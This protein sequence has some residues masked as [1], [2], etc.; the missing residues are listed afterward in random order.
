MA[1]LGSLAET[2]QTVYRSDVFQ[3]LQ[4]HGSDCSGIKEKIFH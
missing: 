2:L 1:G 3:L 4:V